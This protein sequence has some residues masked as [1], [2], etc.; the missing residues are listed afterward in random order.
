MR[1]KTEEDDIVSILTSS[2][3]L[4]LGWRHF[5]WRYLASGWAVTV[6]STFSR[7]PSTAFP[8]PVG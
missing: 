5:S 3:E 6:L 1:G 7:V 4:T 2:S 8:G